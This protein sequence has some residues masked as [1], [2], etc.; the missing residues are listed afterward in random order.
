MTRRYPPRSSRLYDPETEMPRPVIGLDVDGTVGKYHEHFLQFASGY[1]GIEISLEPYDGSVPLAKWIGV[2]KERYRQCKMAFRKGGLK[3]CMPV[4]DGAENFAKTVRKTGAM[5]IICTT[6]PFN[7]LDN[8]DP[9]TR[10]W[11]KRNRIQHDDILHGER[12]YRDLARRFG[13]N[14]VVMVLEDLPE[15]IIQALES[16]CNPVIINRP[17]NMDRSMLNGTPSVPNL[18]AALRVALVR[19]AD[20]EQRN[21]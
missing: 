4:F 21:S 16:N 18:E 13:S 20:Y 10:E 17:H 2:S 5:L 8:I 6:R 1:F 11:L 9:D 15:M 7:M 12:K 3:R 14:R 19:I